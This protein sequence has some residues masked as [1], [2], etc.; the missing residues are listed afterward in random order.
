[1]VGP[2]LAEKAGN[3]AFIVIRKLFD[4]LE[5]NKTLLC[6]SVEIGSSDLTVLWEFMFI[7]L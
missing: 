3:L 7:L 6:V 1:M 4:A 5:P 2:Q